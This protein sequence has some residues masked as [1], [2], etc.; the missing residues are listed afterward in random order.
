MAL[1]AII[2][3]VRAI[4]REI[5]TRRV[6]ESYLELIIILSGTISFTLNSELKLCGLYVIIFY[7]AD[8]IIRVNI[9]IDPFLIIVINLQLL[10]LYCIVVQSYVIH[11]DRLTPP[12]VKTESISENFEETT[13]SADT[14]II[15][16]NSDEFFELGQE[17]VFF[18]VPKDNLVGKL[19]IE[20]ENV[21]PNH[22]LEKITLD[23]S[24]KETSDSSKETSDSSKK[25]SDKT[26][27]PPKNDNLTEILPGKR[28]LCRTRR[29]I[30]FYC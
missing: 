25:T 1:S 14:G 11:K 6:H 16:Q 28:D 29:K 26:F 3:R 30:S 9:T 22:S 13:A 21:M 24:S 23:D 4:I 20:W 2:F 15:D 10:V 18:L 12:K 19:P 7:T 27:Q 5:K 8:L 17:F